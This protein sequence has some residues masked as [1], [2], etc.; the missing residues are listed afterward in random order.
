LFFLPVV[1]LF[2]RRCAN[3]ASAVD[4]IARPLTVVD[5]LFSR[6]MHANCGPS[7]EWGERAH[8]AKALGLDN[9][10]CFARIPCINDTRL[11]DNLPRFSLVRYRGLVQDVFEPEIY[12]A[13]L[14]ESDDTGGQPTKVVTTKYR[15]HVDPAPGKTLSEM[16]NSGFGQRGACY[17]VPLPGET[18]WAREIA[19]QWTASG[20][21][22]EGNNVAPEASQRPKRSLEHDT[23]M[24]TVVA[25]PPPPCAVGEARKQRVISASTAGQKEL[26]TADAFGL[27]FPIPSEEHSRDGC[28]VPCIVKLYDENAE[29]V[30]LC[31]AVEIV[32]VLCINPEMVRFGGKDES[33]FWDA[34]NPSTSMVP[35][36]H[37]LFVRQ[38]PFSNPMMPYTAAWLSDERLASVWQNRFATPGAVEELHKVAL[39]ALAMY[40][41]GDV[42][43]AH[44]VLMLLVSRSFAKHGDHL[45]GAWSLNLGCWPDGLDVNQ[46]SKAIAEFMPRVVHQEVT[47]DTL[48]SQ[49]WRPRKD[50]DANRLVS[51][52]LQV[53][54]GTVVVFDE[55]QM[56]QGQLQDVGVHNLAA[57]R[58]LIVDRVLSCDFST[59]DVKIPLEVH[60]LNVSKQRSI[61]PEQD[62]LLPLCPVQAQPANVPSA[63]LE[64]VRLFL[65][66]VT[67]S[68]RPV[69]FPDE[70]TQRFANDFATAREQHDVRP[71][72][73]HTWMSL[74]RAFC[75][76][77]GVDT[78]TSDRWQAVLELESERLRRCKE[79]NFLS[80]QAQ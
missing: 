67:R 44:Y 51:G 39:E 25:V 76:V 72:L 20:G 60:I 12:A 13:L 49:K 5:E 66:L 63:A 59:C 57:I 18:K 64:A 71:E 1:V 53:S 43:A 74:A 75:I 56:A 11:I 28:S 2:A 58:T 52:R 32:G 45:L 36:L 29:A 26:Q 24:G 48:N 42:L 41:G 7:Q 70:V 10:D 3:M 68:P 80:K 14:E 16:G 23:N 9:E 35:R 34:R 37:A 19:A 77:H 73:C 15:D 4:E 61:I 22:G 31:D 33:P 21:G 54:S 40:L 46:L 50:F 27:N 55:T 62:V 38:L 6:H 78:L 30:R 8:F 47:A 65:A 17:C 69:K 79:N